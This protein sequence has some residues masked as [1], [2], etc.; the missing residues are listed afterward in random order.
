MNRVVYLKMNQADYAYE[1]MTP[2]LLSGLLFCMLFFVFK[3]DKINSVNLNVN[4]KKR[5]Y[6]VQSY[7]MRPT[8][9]YSECCETA[10]HKL[11]EVWQS[12]PRDPLVSLGLSRT[13]AKVKP[14]VCHVIS[15]NSN[16][17][18]GRRKKTSLHL[19]VPLYL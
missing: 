1:F 2:L 5:F 8:V 14:R 7:N 15:V 17:G 12:F 18:T 4:A 10:K 3:C 16:V 13:E 19:N 9:H 11:R 6:S